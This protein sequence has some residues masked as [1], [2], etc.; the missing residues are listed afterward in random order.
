MNIRLLFTGGNGQVATAI[1]H[2]F[3]KHW[4]TQFLSHAALDIGSRESV[5]SAIAQ[6]SPD[7]IINT[8]AFTA[9]DDAEKNPDAAFYANS[10]AVSL[11]AALSEANAIP[12]IHLSTD[13]VFDGDQSSPYQES[14][15]PN[16]L[17]VYG[18]SKW[19]GEEAIR[20]SCEAHIILR[21]SSVFSPYGHNFVKTILR[22]AKQKETL[23]IV[24]DQ[25]H[26]PTSARSIALA[27]QKIIEKLSDKPWGTYHY[28][29]TPQATWYDFCSQI[30]SIG[31]RYQSLKVNTVHATS[32]AEFGALALRPRYSV[33]NC[34]KIRRF[35]DL[36]Q[37]G[38]FEE[39]ERTIA[40]LH[41]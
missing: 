28:C 31:N 9:V 13:Y 4:N 15:T 19:R 26:C 34:A 29:N 8:A 20:K 14:D 32:S 17:N 10:D 1:S 3:P 39:L 12:L 18:L 7:V 27:L 21:V 36:E 41:K 33:L 37:S 35:F 24:A 5:T 38:W 40:L 6:F 16:P 22:L 11:L 2:H 30:I 25:T 23:T